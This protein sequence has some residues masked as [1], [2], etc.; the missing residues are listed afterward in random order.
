MV[1]FSIELMTHMPGHAIL[2]VM[3]VGDAVC[4]GAVAIAELDDRFY[5]F[6]E[7]YHGS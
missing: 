1:R 4:S 7:K 2:A 5:I 3:G 6:A